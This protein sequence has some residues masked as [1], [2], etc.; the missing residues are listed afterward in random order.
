MRIVISQG[1]KRCRADGHCISAQCQSFGHISAIANATRNDELHF[2]VHVQFLKCA[3]G[4][5]DTGQSRLTHMLDEHFLRGCRATLHSVNNDNIC[6]GFHS[7]G[8]VIIRSG[9]A[10]FYIYGFFPIGDFT[11]L[12][13]F[14][15]KIIGPRPIRMTTGRTLIDAF[16]QAAHGGHTI[17]NFLTQQHAAAAGFGTLADHHFNGVGFAQIIGVHAVT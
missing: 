17:R 10:D 12:S 4:W 13:N 5:A 15:F 2:A 7:K 3:N 16:R 14:N 1:H 11:Q 6:T 9:S 8:H